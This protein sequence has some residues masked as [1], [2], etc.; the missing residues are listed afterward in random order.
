LDKGVT[1]IQVPPSAAASGNT[2]FLVYDPQPLPTT[3]STIQF[4][5]LCILATFID[6]KSI[7][8][9]AQYVTPG[10]KIYCEKVKMWWFSSG[11]W[12]FCTKF[13]Q[14]AV[15]GEMAQCSCAPQKKSV[16]DWT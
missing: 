15:P 8:K 12:F 2:L 5:F 7:F 6:P 10:S 1:K 9:S 4:V 14:L 3:K 13:V 11:N 16:I